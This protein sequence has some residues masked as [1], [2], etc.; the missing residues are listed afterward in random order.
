MDVSG[1]RT[2]RG[3]VPSFPPSLSLFPSQLFY[4]NF[5]LSLSLLSQYC[6]SRFF[7]I[8]V[9][10]SFSSGV[11]LYAAKILFDL[12]KARWLMHAAITS[13]TIELSAR[14]SKTPSPSLPLPLSLT[15]Y[16]NSVGRFRS[17]GFSGSKHTSFLEKETK[18]RETNRQTSE[19]LLSEVTLRFSCSPRPPPP[20][21]GRPS[22]S[23]V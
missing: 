13:N 20:K 11:H 7:R 10:V 6:N 4:I 22:C 23:A 21:S 5:S 18:K 17:A 14:T 1:E 15:H 2:R 12:M 3:W 19:S 16:R 8:E 9:F